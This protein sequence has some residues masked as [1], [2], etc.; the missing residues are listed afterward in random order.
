MAV[1]RVRVATSTGTSA[2]GNRPVRTYAVA[3]SPVISTAPGLP[4]IGIGL[5][6]APV[7][8]VM[9][10]SWVAVVPEMTNAVVPSG[11]MAMSTGP[12]GT[13]IGVP[14]VPLAM[15]TGTTV[16]ALSLTT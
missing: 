10:T 9:A 15:G 4:A 8:S 14:G 3:P 5:L 1:P 6:T 11:V 13:V 7:A 2:G 16:L 12:A